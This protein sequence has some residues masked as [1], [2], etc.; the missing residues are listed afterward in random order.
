MKLSK[1]TTINLVIAAA[2]LSSCNRDTEARELEYMP[3][4]YRSYAI[5]AQEESPTDSGKT[6]M[7][8]PP[9]GT[10]PRGHQPY[11]FAVADGEK[12][13]NE[14]INPLPMS[15]EILMTGKKYYDI[16]CTPCHGKAGA[17]DGNVITKAQYNPRM[18]KPPVLYSQKLVDY[19]DGQLFHIISVGQGNMPAYA[20]RIDVNTRWAIV[21]YVRTIQNTAKRSL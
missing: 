6:A 3:D 15:A 14:L 2:V 16:N 9:K 7:L 10:I 19:K 21:N 20:N 12:A 4:M 1:L 17:G 11:L 18:P 13:G 5:K 8:L